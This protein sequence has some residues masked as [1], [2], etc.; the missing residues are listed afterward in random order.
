M[1][2]CVS[3]TCVKWGCGGVGNAQHRTPPA[4]LRH[5]GP[6]AAAAGV[7][8]AM[9]LPMSRPRRPS[10]QLTK[11]RR[12]CLNLPDTD[13][14]YQPVRWGRVALA[15]N[16]CGWPAPLLPPAQ[17]AALHSS[18][19]TQP[20]CWCH[21]APP[22]LHLLHLLLQIFTSGNYLRKGHRQALLKHMRESPVSAWPLSNPFAFKNM[23]K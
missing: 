7:C 21:L 19:I 6:A 2:G 20:C 1:W 4:L 8:S 11:E 14:C 18:R 22:A 5:L 23:H 10:P 3:V 16:P 15:W 13:C 9:S 12:G 17:V